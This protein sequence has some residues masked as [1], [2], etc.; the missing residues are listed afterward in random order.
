MDISPIQFHLPTHY[1]IIMKGYYFGVNKYTSLARA[2]PL[3]EGG[4]TPHREARKRSSRWR[5]RW[6]KKYTSCNSF[7]TGGIVGDARHRLAIQSSTPPIE[8]FAAQFLLLNLFLHVL[9]CYNFD[10]LF[11]LISCCLLDWDCCCK[12]SSIQS[13]QKS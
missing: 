5:K 4:S 12:L 7:N 2:E 10:D 11:P 8:F 13:D 9:W 1:P 3:N 6:S